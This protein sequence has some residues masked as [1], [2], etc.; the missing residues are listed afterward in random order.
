MVMFPLI[1]CLSPDVVCQRAFAGRR[2]PARVRQNAHGTAFVNRTLILIARNLAMGG[3]S[4]PKRAESAR[5]ERSAMGRTAMRARRNRLAIGLL[6]SIILPHVSVAEPS[7]AA[8]P[9]PLAHW[10]RMPSGDDIARVY[11]PRA[12]QMNRSGR[13]II[14]CSVTAQGTLSDCSIVSEDPPEFGFGEA[15]L[16]LAHLFKM[17]PT[18]PSGVAVTDAT[19]KIPI[20]FDM[21]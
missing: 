21:R 19:V 11:P 17:N 13:A 8:T 16:R 7:A 3:K 5:G 1:V 10:T 20:H 9:P 4:R 18:T 15:A 14:N 12:E 2:L 6:A